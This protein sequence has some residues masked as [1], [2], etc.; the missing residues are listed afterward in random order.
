MHRLFDFIDFYNIQT[1]IKIFEILIYLFLFRQKIIMHTFFT[2]SNLL[3]DDRECSELYI[4]N[5][6]RFTCVESIQSGE[7]I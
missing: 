5:I 1:K 6:L 3:F 2:T 7:H 4:L